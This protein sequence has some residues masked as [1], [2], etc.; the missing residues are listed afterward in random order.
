MYFITSIYTIVWPF[1]FL[2]ILQL[3]S[4]KHKTCFLLF[5]NSDQF[6]VCYSTSG[7]QNSVGS[8]FCVYISVNNKSKS[9]E[10]GSSLYYNLREDCYLVR[11]NDAEAS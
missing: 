9:H 5:L 3:I 7:S 4:K 1:A 10:D 11:Q 2:C 8:T 6:A